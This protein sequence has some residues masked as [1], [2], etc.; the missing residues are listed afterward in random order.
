MLNE[1]KA[2][3]LANRA[4]TENGFDILENTLDVSYRQRGLSIGIEKKG[5]VVCYDLNVPSSFE[6]SLVFVHVS[7]PDGEVN[8]PD[9]L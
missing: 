1:K 9:V 6:P 7:D 3:T 5:W 4:L 8:I 2:V